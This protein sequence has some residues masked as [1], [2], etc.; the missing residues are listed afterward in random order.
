VG[1][2]KAGSRAVE[3]GKG[4]CGPQARSCRALLDG[5]LVSLFGVLGVGGI[6]FE[7]D[8]ARKQAKV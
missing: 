6:A 4:E 3:F 8:I 7:Q 1:V 2:A 5:R